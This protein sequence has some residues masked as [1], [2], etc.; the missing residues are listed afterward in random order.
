[1]KEYLNDKL[2][3]ARWVVRSVEQRRSTLMNVARCVVDRQ[4]RFF[5]QGPGHLRPLLLTD[6]AQELEVHESTVSRA[7]KDKYL[8]CAHG[9]FPMGYFFS[10]G[11]G[12]AGE[13]GVSPDRAKTRLRALI[14]GED[15][16]KPLSDQKLAERLAAEGVPLSRRTVAK[17]RD[18]LGIPSTAGRKTF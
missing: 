11:L 5:R 7:L 16:K 12:G 18:E 2:K 6:V 4:E 8:Q 15:K 10:R 14:D 3:Q 17:Y 9:V 13:E 1:M